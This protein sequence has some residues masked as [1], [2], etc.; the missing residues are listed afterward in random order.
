MSKIII[1]D[2]NSLLFRAYYATFTDDPAK[3]M[4]SHDGTPTNALFAF[5]N[6]IASLLKEIKKDDAI[7]VAFDAGKHTFRHKEYKEYKANRP[8]CPKELLE[9]I[10]IVKEFLNALNIFYYEDENFEADD[11]AGNIA[12]KAAKNNY[13]VEIYTSDKDYLQ[14]IDNKTTVN[15]IKRG[16]KDI[17]KMT[18]DTFKEEWG[19]E[20]FKIVDYKGLMGDPSDNLKGIPKVGD[21]TAKKLI[22]EYGDLETIIANASNIKGK[23]G[24]NIKQYQDEG[25]MCKHLA[26]IQTENELNIAIEDLIYKGYNLEKIVEFCRDFDL[27]TLVNKLPTSFRISTNNEKITYKEVLNFNQIDIPEIFGISIDIENINYHEAEM[28]GLALSFKDE[29]YYISLN[30]LLNDKK[31]LDILANENYQKCCFDFK[32]IKVVLNNNNI[33]INGLYFDLMLASYLQNSNFIPTIDGCLASEGID[34]NYAL[35]NTNLLFSS[36]SLLS[37]V[38]AHYSYLLKNKYITNLKEHHEYE[39]FRDIEEKLCIVLADMESEGFPVNKEYLLTLKEEYTKKLDKISKE[40]YTLAGEE[41]NIN[42]PKQVANII[43]DKLNLQDNKNHSTSIEYL[44]YLIDKHPI[45]PLILDYRKYSKLVSTYVDGI[46]PFIQKDNKIH[47]TFNQAL[48]TTGRL[49]SSE[50][51]LQNIT[52]RDEESRQIRKAFF[53]DDPNLEILSLDYSQ[54]EL[55]ILAHLANSET[56]INAFNSDEDIHAL[57]ARKVFK[58]PNEIELDPSLRRKAKAVNFG[59]IYG[60]S[61]W[62]LSEQLEIPVKESREI[63]LSF[64]ENFPEIKEYLN[65]LVEKAAS[66]GYAE[67]MFNRRRYLPKMNSSQYQEREFAKRAAMN[68][69]IQGSA[70]DLIK[71]SM[72][73]VY[74]AL[75]ENHLKSKIVNQIHD[76]IILKVYKDEKEQVFNLVKEIMENCVELKVKLKADGGYGR[77]W[78]DTK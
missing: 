21:K 70:A 73:K 41:F 58:I 74:D 14:L 35:K 5:S 44:K 69:P 46:V 33:Q 30:N 55:R 31:L 32:K 24:E 49:S 22:N 39:L 1:I 40:I 13:T 57:T 11:I 61:D 18:E 27:K 68:A 15:L 9:Q 37:A 78:F 65:L 64:Y 75:K 67:T 17:A 25:R 3:L 34:I 45:I 62:G 29:N 16:L 19:F 4:R 53:Y 6:M 38:E 10:P 72:I 71:I 52:I 76:E 23:L 43:Y 77:S 2:G 36:N 47:A 12:R 56:L 28:Y 60:I 48:T 59:I 54:I 42:S 51:N 7:F 66:K 50:P 63:I 8:P 20:P 26:I